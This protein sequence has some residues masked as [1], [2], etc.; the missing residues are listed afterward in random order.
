M[1]SLRRAEI[2]LLC[3]DIKTSGGKGSRF[4]SVLKDMKTILDFEI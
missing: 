1:I 4:W 3:A 2:G